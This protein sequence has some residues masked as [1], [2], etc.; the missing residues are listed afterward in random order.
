MWPSDV[1]SFEYFIHLK[2]ALPKQDNKKV[3]FAIM[4][5]LPFFY[6]IDTNE[7]PGFFQ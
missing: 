2:S 7:I 1:L 4:N 6:Y 3:N 5:Q